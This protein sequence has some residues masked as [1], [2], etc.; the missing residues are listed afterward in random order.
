MFLLNVKHQ[1]QNSQ[2]SRRVADDGGY[3]APL[4]T[5]SRYGKALLIEDI[6]AIPGHS[7]QKQ[8]SRINWEFN[9]GL[10][11]IESW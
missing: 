5:V 7:Y 2:F 9:R 8:S 10:Y 11:G 4:R 6:L 1:N 3:N